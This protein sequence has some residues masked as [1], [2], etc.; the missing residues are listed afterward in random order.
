L[1]IGL[2]AALALALF[3]G[4]V[5]RASAQISNDQCLK[6]HGDPSIARMKPETLWGM[7]RILPEEGPVKRPA[8]TVVDLYTPED[9]FMNS[10]HGSL[11]CTGCHLGIERLPHT[12]HLAEVS[13]ANCHSN[14]VAELN[15]GAHRPNVQDGLA[16]PWCTDCH[17]K[18]HGVMSLERP[19]SYDTSV[20]S[21]KAC[22]RCHHESARGGFNPAE[23]YRDNIHGRAL[24]KAGLAVAPTCADCHGSHKMRGEDDPESPISHMNVVETCGKC[25]E[26]VAET[27]LKSI[28]G[29][30][31]LEGKSEEATCTSCHRSHGITRVDEP[32][33]LAVVQECSHCH[34]DLGKSYLRSYHGKATQ[35]G[36]GSAAVCSSCHGAH[37]ILPPSDPNSRVNKGNLVK[38]CGKCHQNAN[39]N[40]IKY[41]A[42]VDFLDRKA[43]P[44][45]FWTF[46]V[47]TFLLLSVLALFIP[48]TLLWFQRTLVDRLKNPRGPH[49]HDTQ[50]RMIRRF[51]PIHRFTHGLIV[52]SFMGLVA[53]GFPLKYSYTEWAH[54]LTRAFGGI[55]V[56]GLAHR[57]LA[58]I[59]FTYAA[60][61]VAFLV[62][63]FLTK[64][65]KPRWKYLF[66]PDSLI[67]SWSDFKDFIAMMKWFFRLGPRPKFD[68]WTYFEKFD[69]W[70]EIWGVFVI[71]GSGLLLWFPTLFT[72][73]LPGW[74]L[75]CA[76][77]VHSIEALLAASVIFLV[78]FFNTHLR[79]EKFP[80]DMVMWTGQMTES[81]MQEE[82]GTEYQRLVESGQLENRVVKPVQRR[83]RILGAV[84]GICAFLFGLF[85]IALALGTEL[86][87][88]TR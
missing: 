72:R 27:Y 20:A 58:I 65:S 42:H 3:A 86:S 87:Q 40:F 59:T 67:F 13:C 23:T 10:V 52:V 43:N 71:G 51:R 8:E 84:L 80:I 35:L 29:Q 62:Y 73:W 50:E 78:H 31:L 85:L 68:R 28:H 79:P 54:N 1:R 32:F 15:T 33:L 24:F 60:V 49:A 81:E 14:V 70:G 55:Q 88:F 57:V 82:R 39:E 34:I 36:M 9:V 19:R 30:L 47:M 46:V 76:M 48:H 38:T 11:N 69:Y 2:V 45:V 18:T 83:W 26:G 5:E 63:F 77:V 61:H 75:T 12:Q 17:G 22:E 74:E 44:E 64:C 53:T 66:G 6:C 4:R 7:V 21:V 25:H 41:I 16:R 37:D 56:M